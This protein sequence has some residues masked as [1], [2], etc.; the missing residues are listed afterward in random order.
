MKI[1]DDTRRER[2][3]AVLRAIEKLR[4]AFPL[5]TAVEAADPTLRTA[6]VNALSHWIRCGSPP[7][8]DFLSEAATQALCALDALTVDEYGIGCYPFS[9]HDTG[10][11]AHFA[12]HWVSAMCAIDALA[13]SRLAQHDSRVTARCAVCRCHLTCA[14]AANGSV[15]GGNPDGVRVAWRSRSAAEGACYRILCPGIR[16][17]CR[18]CAEHPG[19]LG[20][21]LPEAAA[22][23]NS[24][25]AFQR[26][27]LRHHEHA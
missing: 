20:L 8:R 16:F 24:F 22:V 6:Y 18:H 7:P 13:I 11:Y 23:G 26:R 12:G 5:Q 19:A 10:V 21:S 14:V 25:F 9:A 2:K 3:A 1:S 15:E 17:V 4:A 27:L